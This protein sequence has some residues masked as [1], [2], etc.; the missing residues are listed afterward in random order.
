MAWGWGY[1][2]F[3]TLDDP[4]TLTYDVTDLGQKRGS[5]RNYFSQVSKFSLKTIYFLLK[6]SKLKSDDG[7]RDDRQMPETTTIF[8]RALAGDRVPKKYNKR[9]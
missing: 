4:L 6:S 2:Y 5:Y 9:Q 3:N 1:Q 7:Q 8:S